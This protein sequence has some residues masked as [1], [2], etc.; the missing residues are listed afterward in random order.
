MIATNREAT[1]DEGTTTPERPTCATCA[2]WLAP[3]ASYEGR[4]GNCRKDLVTAKAGVTVYPEDFCGEHPDF[5]AFVAATRPAP[6]VMSGHSGEVIFENGSS[7]TFGRWNATASPVA[8]WDDNG[9]DKP[10]ESNLIAEVPPDHEWFIRF[11]TIAEKIAGNWPH[12][13]MFAPEFHLLMMDLKAIL[14][15]GQEVCEIS[16]GPEYADTLSADMDAAILHGNYRRLYAAA[17]SLGKQAGMLGL[18]WGGK[19]ANLSHALD[20]LPENDPFPAEDVAWLKNELAKMT[21]T[22][23]HLA[24]RLHDSAMNNIAQRRE[25]GQLRTELSRRNDTIAAFQARIDQLEGE[26]VSLRRA[27]LPVLPLTLDVGPIREQTKELAEKLIAEQVIPLR[28]AAIHACKFML[29]CPSLD[30]IGKGWQNAKL[31]AGNLLKDAL[32]GKPES[33]DVIDPSFDEAC[34]EVLKPTVAAEWPESRRVDAEW[35][36]ELDEV[37]SDVINQWPDDDVEFDEFDATINRLIAIRVAGHSAVVPLAKPSAGE[38]ERIIQLEAELT[39]ARAKFRQRGQTIHQLNNRIAELRPEITELRQA[40]EN[41]ANTIRG[42][43]AEREKRAARLVPLEVAS[44][45]AELR[46]LRQ[47]LVTVM[48]AGRSMVEEWGG[49]RTGKVVNLTTWTARIRDFQETLESVARK[50]A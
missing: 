38:S 41:Q 43:W 34:G 26:K 11:R 25:T 17:K 45:G 33:D 39:K 6:K 28:E 31:Y 15:E 20:A 36:A 18:D 13:N 47:D 22:K 1:Q 12:N 2:Y 30:P 5:P 27:V 21:E 35:F 24:R 29:T 40:N 48:S 23:N 8:E 14:K 10:A 16:A 42:F 37:I 46:D 32:E 9:A 4:M 19:W 3:P 44:I 7:I 50:N 49:D